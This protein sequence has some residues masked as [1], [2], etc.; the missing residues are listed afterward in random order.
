MDR[1]AGLLEQVP[2]N[3]KTLFRLGFHCPKCHSSPGVEEEGHCQDGKNFSFISSPHPHPWSF[4]RQ[5]KSRKTC[6]ISVLHPSSFPLS[7][8]SK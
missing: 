7:Q 6:R 3:P 8:S 1:P 2:Q 4:P 5:L